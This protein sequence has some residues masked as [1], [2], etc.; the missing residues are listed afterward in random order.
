MKQRALI[1]YTDGRIVHGTPVTPIRLLEDLRGGSF[2]VSFAAPEQLT[3]A[4]QLT[5]EDEVCILD[6]GAWSIHAAHEK[7]KKL[8]K[9]VALPKRLQFASAHEYRV[10]F[11]RWANFAQTMHPQSIAVVPDVIMGSAEENL[12]EASWALKGDAGIGCADYP[13]RTMFIWHMD[14]PLSQLKLAAQIF[15]FI[16]IG[17]CAEFD[18]QKQ[19]PAYRARLKHASAMLDW[20]ELSTGRRPWVHLMRGLGIYHEFP[21]FQSADSANVAV[22]HCRHRAKHGEARVRHLAGRVHHK[23]AHHHTMRREA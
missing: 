7:A 20:V 1:P 8:G 13:E 5:G 12:L 16:G 4:Q 15:N 22:N 18:V 6:N 19:R 3:E 9:P 10:A 14:E 17:S 11:W 2:C 23:I 21:R